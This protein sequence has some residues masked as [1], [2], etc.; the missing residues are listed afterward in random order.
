MLS[1]LKITLGA[2]L[3]FC[4]LAPAPAMSQS[5]PLSARAQAAFDQGMA[6]VDQQDWNS[7]V[8]RFLEA[9]KADPQAPQV[10]FN[11]GL[12][13]SKIPA[14]E[15]RAIA[16]FKSYLL[17][18]PHAE[19]A[20]AVRQKV[21]ELQSGYEARL[22]EIIDVLEQASRSGMDEAIREMNALPQDD[23]HTPAHDKA[24]SPADIGGLFAA[25]HLYLGDVQ[26]AKRAVAAFGVDPFSK[27]RVQEQFMPEY[28]KLAAAA[29]KIAVH[30]DCLTN[31]HP[32]EMNNEAAFVE[33]SDG[34]DF[35]K[36][37]DDEPAGYWNFET[38]YTAEFKKHIAEGGFDSDA[39]DPDSGWTPERAYT[40]GWLKKQAEL[41]EKYAPMMEKL[42]KKVTEDNDAK[43]RKNYDL[44]EMLIIARNGQVINVVKFQSAILEQ[45]EQYEDHK[46]DETQLNEF[47]STIRR[48]L[49][50]FDR[51]NPHAT[52]ANE[53]DD[54]IAAVRGDS[55]ANW[56]NSFTALIAS[57][58]RMRM[59]AS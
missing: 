26:A 52:R 3:S 46:F 27:C 58:N 25:M 33:S 14:N 6:A 11:L 35:P 17:A 29:A 15:F 39:D 53:L 30:A 44:R 8:A 22:K 16:W 23:Y 4:L 54:N 41:H 48:D 43:N 56:I 18:N 55:L 42:G 2:L 59:S 12:A 28:F 36:E 50:T 37:K 13:S 34:L 5:T 19:N 57:Y 32:V 20:E 21:G 49:E 7:A 24:Y 9:Q 40:P 38:M 1:Y 45:P 31:G 51:L 10:L 47:V